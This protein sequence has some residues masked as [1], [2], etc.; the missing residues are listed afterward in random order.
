[1]L[2]S[3]RPGSSVAKN[4]TI[5]PAACGR[6]ASRFFLCGWNEEIGRG[7]RRVATY[8]PK[9]IPDFTAVEIDNQEILQEQGG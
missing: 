3:H 2:E 4:A 8:I 1:M 7:E 6:H 5:E 9:P